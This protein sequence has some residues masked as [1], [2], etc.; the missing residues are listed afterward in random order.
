MR[1]GR[2]PIT[3]TGTQMEKKSKKIVEKLEHVEL[4]YEYK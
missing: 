4:E 1:R 2:K 3:T